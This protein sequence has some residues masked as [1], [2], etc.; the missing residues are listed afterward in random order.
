MPGIPSAAEV[1][2]EGIQVG[3]MQKK[4]MEKIEELSLYIIQLNDEN[5]SLKKDMDEMKDEIQKLKLK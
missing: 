4:M 1:K 5:K 2:E 3:D